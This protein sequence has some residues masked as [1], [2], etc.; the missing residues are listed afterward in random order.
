V[1]PGEYRR[2]VG[3]IPETRI[4]LV[5]DDASLAR[6][7]CE[8]L[9]DEGAR[10]C[11]PLT[12]TRREVQRSGGW[13]LLILDWGLPCPDGLEVLVGHRRAGGTT[14]AFFLTAPDAAS[15]RVRGLDCGADDCPCKPLAFDELLARA[16]ISRGLPAEIM[17]LA[18]RE[19]RADLARRRPSGRDVPWTS[20]PGSS[21]CSLSSFATR[22]RS[23]RGRGSTGTFGARIATSYP[24]PRMST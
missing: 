22:T 1:F 3:C 9:S 20:R 24:T 7:V 5:E 21:P 4:L 6:A 17:T 13:D 10:S 18:Y 2:A 12:E 15:D 8:G 11:T 16:L 19:V 23:C 14:P